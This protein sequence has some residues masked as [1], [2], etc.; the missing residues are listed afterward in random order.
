MT[1]NMPN[2]AYAV[3]QPLTPPPAGLTKLLYRWQIVST[4]RA[5]LVAKLT[6]LARVPLTQLLA[7]ET[8]QNIMTRNLDLFRQI[9]IALESA[10]EPVDSCNIAIDGFDSDEITYHCLLLRDEE[11]ILVTTEFNWS[12]YKHTILHITRLTN[13]GH[14]FAKD[15]RDENKWKVAK[16]VA[17]TAH[18]ITLPALLS[19]LQEMAKTGLTARWGE[20]LVIIQGMGWL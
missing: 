1:P 7:A 6:V 12:N 2:A 15:V 4:D 18:A 20:L 19:I 14:D 5:D 8:K 11:L 3:K 13:K 16:A 9:V 10:T 17:S